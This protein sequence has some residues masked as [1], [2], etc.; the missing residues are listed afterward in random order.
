MLR[1][2]TPA[3]ER[4]K[5]AKYGAAAIFHGRV[6]CEGVSIQVGGSDA[7]AQLSLLARVVFRR[8]A[9]C[10]DSVQQ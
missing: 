4:R 8:I 9:R 10:A 5:A 6:S 3:V 1:R 2:T 7:N